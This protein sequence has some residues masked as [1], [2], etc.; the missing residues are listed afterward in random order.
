M[1]SSDEPY[2]LILAG[3]Q[4]SRM[5]KDKSALNYHG[6][7]QLEFLFNLLRKLVEKTY[8]S[9]RKGQSVSFTDQVIEDRFSTKGPI[10]GILSAL[11][12]WPDKSWLVLAVDLPF[13][14]Q[15][16]IEQLIEGRDKTSLATAFATKE[17][18]LPEPLVALWEARS[19]PILKKFHIDE[20]M[21][22][23][24]KF[25]LSHQVHLIHPTDDRE[26]YNANYPEEYQ[27]AKSLI[28]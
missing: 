7:P 25:M 12:A 24:R 6:Q 11:S 20:D 5:G 1:T 13:I 10:N 27:F 14:S 26:L 8:V 15:Q 21:R 22:C 16:T 17:S 18:G 3:G 4:S 23:P 9:V 28:K 19:R 2:G